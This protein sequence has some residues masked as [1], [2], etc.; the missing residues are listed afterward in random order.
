MMSFFPWTR[1]YKAKKLAERTDFG[2]CYGWFIEKQGQRLG[3]LDY[4]R[5][6]SVAQFWHE[7][8]LKWYNESDRGM[9]ADQERWVKEIVLRNKRYTDV[10]IS[11]SLVAPEANGIVAVRYASV[12]LDRFRNDETA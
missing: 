1:A 9:E 6:D 12:P 4:I 2:R 7:Y 10:V 3:E 8:S 11:G 5:W